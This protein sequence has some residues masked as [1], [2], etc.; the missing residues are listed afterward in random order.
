MEQG[1]RVGVT[2]AYY[3]R[4]LSNNYSE[5]EYS[6]ALERLNEAL[7]FYSLRCNSGGGGGPPRRFLSARQGDAKLCTVV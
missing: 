7:V 2:G 4:E 1:I 3:G 6:A 5:E